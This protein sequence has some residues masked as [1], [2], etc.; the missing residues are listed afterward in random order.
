MSHSSLKNIDLLVGSIEMPM[1]FPKESSFLT[2]T[3]ICGFTI[4]L[5]FC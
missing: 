4:S 1:V 2:D 3:V 5:I